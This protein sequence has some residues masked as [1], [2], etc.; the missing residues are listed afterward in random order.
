MYPLHAPLVQAGPSLSSPAAMSRRNKR[1]AE[2]EDRGDGELMEDSMLARGP[3]F[4]ELE[5]AM[6]PASDVYTAMQRQLSC[7]EDVVVDAGAV[8]KGPSILTRVCPVI[9][10]SRL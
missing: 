8:G 5:E 9:N 2:P 3:E 1:A 6:L 10:T 4:P 7:Y